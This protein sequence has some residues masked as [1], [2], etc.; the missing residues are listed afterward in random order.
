MSRIVTSRQQNWGKV[1]I[2]VMSVCLPVQGWVQGGGFYVTIINDVLN[3]TVKEP[4]SPPWTQDLRIVP[5]S[6]P[7]AN[8]IWQSSLETYS[9]FKSYFKSS[10]LFFNLVKN[11]VSQSFCGQVTAS[12][13]GSIY[14]LLSQIMGAFNIYIQ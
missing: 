5:S 2:S 12:Y 8:N 3:V 9:N 11:L 1:V 14:Y 6:G 4:P 13:K 7:P 10:K